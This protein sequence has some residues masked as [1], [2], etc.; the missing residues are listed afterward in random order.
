V[1]G[2]QQRMPADT[3]TQIERALRAP[4]AFNSGSS[5]K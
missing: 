3:A 4:R 5:L 2:E 1:L